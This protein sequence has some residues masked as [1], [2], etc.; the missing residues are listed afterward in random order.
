[1]KRLVHEWTV[2]EL[3]G[4][5]A[6][7]E[8]PEYQREP[9]L[10][11]RDAKQKLVDS[12]LRA[13]DIASVYFYLRTDGILECI[14]GRQRLNA[15]MS[16]LGQ[17][18]VDRMDNGFPFRV[19]NE[20]FQEEQHPFADLNGLPFAEIERIAS[21]GGGEAAAELAADLERAF[22]TYKVTV[23]LL[24]DARRPEEFNLQFLRLNLGVLVNAGEKLNAMVGEMRDIVFG[25]DGLGAHPFLDLVE[26]PTRR[27]AREVVAAQILCQA[28]SLRYGGG[29]TRTRHYDLQRFFKQFTEVGDR[30]QVVE[31]ITQTLDWLQRAFEGEGHLLQSR[32]MTVSIVLL[33][34]AERL[35]LEEEVAAQFVAFV[36][37][38]VS[39]LRRQLEN[40]KNFRVDRE[41]HYLVDFQRDVTQ[42]AVERPA[43]ERR[44][45][46]LL[47]EWIR[48]RDEGE[49]LREEV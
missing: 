10:W 38:F 48:W 8:F 26:I 44:H 9:H 49:I 40:M 43:V 16:Y 35:F 41:Y 27:Y 24:S 19:V 39:Q 14:D 20:V 30:R 3:A 13:F 42:A 22:L 28:F 12:I 17:N 37:E 11:D 25:E 46:R 5:F 33:V 7:I 23:V 1:M 29:F 21:Q 31:E 18:P 2:S 36:K 34:W 6:E 4:R 47:K 15:I 32:A 45:E